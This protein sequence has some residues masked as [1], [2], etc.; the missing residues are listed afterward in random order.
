MY[1]Q[2]WA[3]GAIVAAA[4]GLLLAILLFSIKTNRLPNR[5]L[6]F[7]MLLLVV[8]LIEW[9]L[10][11]THWIAQVPGFK[12]ISFPLQ[13]FY[14]PA[15]YLY[16]M[17][18]FE[19]QQ[20]SV[21]KTLWHALPFAITV[22]LLLPF[23]LRFYPAITAYL[24]WI[25]QWPTNPWYLIPVFIQ[26]ILYGFWM[27]TLIRPHVDKNPELKRWSKWLLG[28]YW[29]IV[30]TFLYYRLSHVIGLHAFKWRQLDAVSLTFFIYL[31]AWLGY[32]EPRVF[33]GMTLQEAIKPIKYRN[34]VLS[35][36]N[37]RALFQRILEL[38]ETK[39]LF[40]N[41]EL[42][43]NGLAQ[44]LQ[45]QRHHVSQAINEQAGK[46]FA[47]FVNEY[48]VKAAQNLLTATSKQELNAIEVAYQVGFG[49]K[50]AF[51][52]AF[53]KITGTTPTLYRQMQDKKA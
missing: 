46:S 13:L 32:I 28:A 36:E 20:M 49:T 38:M 16:F 51:N 43:L 35:A 19:P 25:P 29:G 6:G 31:V 27:R 9:A 45:A 47:E 21:K 12:V 42:S 50:N 5:I 8:T 34:S 26:M 17:A 48:R 37:S 44:Q 23:F 2:I 53:K 15:L 1:I 39:E 4:Q 3:I 24:D 33:A 7:L 30:C 52:L 41:S 11:W 40:R 18:T 22:F 14:G 10:W